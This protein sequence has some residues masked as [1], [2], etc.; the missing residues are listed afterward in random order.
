MKQQH[1]QTALITGATGSIGQALC[2]QFAA[3]H[4]NLVLVTRN[5]Q[6]LERLS[7]QLEQEFDINIEVISLDLVDGN[8]VSELQSILQ[9]RHLKIDYLINNAGMGFY[10]P[11]THTKP[12]EID[13]MIN[14]NITA[15]VQLTR[16]IL[17]SMLAQ[18]N[19]R[20]LNVASLAA[21][22]PGGPNAAVYYA[23]KNFV[24]AFNRALSL[25]LEKTPVTCTAFCPG[26]L[27]TDFST[28]G[29]FATT[30]LYRYFRGNV[31]K[32]V[33]IGYRGLFKGKRVVV[34]GLVNKLLAFGGEFPPRSIALLL[35]KFLLNK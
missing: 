35:N 16:F 34:P 2:R 32:Q 6:K 25:E 13:N 9:Q 26:P 22:Q 8:V 23:S 4:I 29:G 24:L 5:L 20:I 10:S 28:K 7:K 12:D 33:A 11:L 1:P 31:E 21:L 17:P 15:L 14:L 30:R 19:G 18:G 3:D 27:Q